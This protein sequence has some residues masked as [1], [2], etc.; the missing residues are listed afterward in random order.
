MSSWLVSL[1]WIGGRVER[2]GR[3]QKKHDLGAACVL[4]SPIN[5]SPCRLAAEPRPQIIQQRCNL[6]VIHAARE[7]RHDRAALSFHGSNAAPAASPFGACAEG[8]LT[9]ASTASP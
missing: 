6:A 2:P 4:N 3:C 9:C 1:R 8:D 7:A 5:V